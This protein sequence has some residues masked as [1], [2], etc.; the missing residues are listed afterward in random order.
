MAYFKVG[1]QEFDG[2]GK[3]EILSGNYKIRVGTSSK[4]TPAP[5]EPSLNGSFSVN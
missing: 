1:A 4:I 3:W 5:A 2:N